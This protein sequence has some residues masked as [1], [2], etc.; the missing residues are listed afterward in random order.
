MNFSSKIKRFEEEITAQQ[1]TSATT[2]K[3][4]SIPPPKKPLV[5]AQDLKAIKADE[6]ARLIK[7]LKEEESYDEDEIADK[8]NGSAKFS[9]Q[10][11]EHLLND[12]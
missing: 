10:Q 11:F 9:D 7:I 5:S 4:R 2:T 6:E 12:R 8:L 3:A 1:G